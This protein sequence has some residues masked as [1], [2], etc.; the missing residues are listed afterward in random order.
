MKHVMTICE[1]AGV[2]VNWL[3]Q[4]VGLK[5]GMHVDAA[6]LGILEAI[7]EL[8]ADDRQ[9]TF[10]FIRYKIQTADGWYA[11]EKLARYMGML[12]KIIKVPKGAD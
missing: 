11:K 12:D 1:F 10:D 4:G 3:L 9:Q 6:Q 2:N 7:D 5:R 8:P